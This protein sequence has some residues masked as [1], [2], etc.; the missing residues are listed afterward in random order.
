[1]GFLEGV[2]WKLLT[3][4]GEQRRQK[5]SLGSK[6]EPADAKALG[7]GKRVELL[8]IDLEQVTGA[9]KLRKRSSRR[10]NRTVGRIQG[11]P[12]TSPRGSCWRDGGPRFIIY[13]GH[14]GTYTYETCIHR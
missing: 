8:A 5:N 7:M 2:K 4:E 11:S 6:A 12:K 10:H 13:K 14:P 3:A 9:E 1:M